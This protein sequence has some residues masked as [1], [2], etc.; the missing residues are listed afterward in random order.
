VAPGTSCQA[1]IGTFRNSLVQ[2]FGDTVTHLSKIPVKRQAPRSL[3]E[4]VTVIQN[5]ST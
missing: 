2:L 3:T 4:C 1:T 5:V